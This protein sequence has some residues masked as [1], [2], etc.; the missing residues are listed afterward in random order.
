MNVGTGPTDG[1]FVNT[2]QVMQL[3]GVSR[4]TV[5]QWLRTRVLV[6]F[7]DPNKRNLFA[8][9]QVEALAAQRAHQATAR[10]EQA[11]RR[12]QARTQQIAKLRAR[13]ARLQNSALPA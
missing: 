10:R 3:L 1:P 9:N 4:Q 11:S 8:K 13:L 5:Q 12:A 6:A 7:P 2:A